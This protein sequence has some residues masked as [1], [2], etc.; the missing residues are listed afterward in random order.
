MNDKENLPMKK[1]FFS[2]LVPVYNAEKTLQA[3]VE[4]VLMQN[5]TDYELI[6]SNDGSKDSSGIIIDDYAKTH[7]FIKAYHKENE[8]L[9]PTRRFMIKKSS[10]E[11]LLFLD[12]DDLWVQGLLDMAY[13]T[14][15]KHGA[16]M[17][18]FAFDKINAEGE[19]RFSS[20]GIF[21]DQTV[22]TPSNK[23][24]IY[25]EMSRGS[26]LNSLWTKVIKRDIV[27][28]DADYR[29]WG[30]LSLGEDLLQSLPL[31][32][33]AKK[34]VWRNQSYYRYRDNDTGMCENFRPQ[35]ILDI[36]AVRQAL[37]QELR[38]EGYD[39]PDIIDAFFTQYLQVM[40]LQILRIT[41]M[42]A[43][44]ATKKEWLQKLGGLYLF[45]QAIAMGCF[46]KLPK[47]DRF[48]LFL[49]EKL[50]NGAFLF[51]VNAKRVRIPSAGSY[52]TSRMNATK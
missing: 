46:K 39:T 52:E 5:F 10:G 44:L 37:Y 38:N 40:V 6:L 34:I 8:G 21:P 43:A 19:V 23:E 4:S 29:K 32:K 17:V 7:P 26:W 49:F 30:R 2:I 27:D 14:I 35:Y 25:A 42:K 15:A 33:S 1:P 12:S 3:C 31:F 45:Q 9:L 22:I 20:V 16:D 24:L 18:L 48:V 50:G 36:D 41:H 47:R 13:Q 51:L 11:Y 28:M